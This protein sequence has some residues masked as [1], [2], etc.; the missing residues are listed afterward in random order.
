MDRRDPGRLAGALGGNAVVVCG[1]VSRERQVGEHHGRTERRGDREGAGHR[2]QSPPTEAQTRR[3]GDG[4]SHQSICE[5][6]RARICERSTRSR[7]DEPR[8]GRQ[9]VAS[10]YR[11]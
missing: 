8:V 1:C 5:H 10:F 11:Y 6:R 2:Q 4:R 3:A 9:H 7:G